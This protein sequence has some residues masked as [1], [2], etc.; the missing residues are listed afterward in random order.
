[1]K[2]KD[3][4]KDGWPEENDETDF[5]T[6]EEDSPELN[7][8]LGW[9][10]CLAAIEPIKEMEVGVDENQFIKIVSNLP[11]DGKNVFTVNLFKEPSYLGCQVLKLN[12]DGIKYLLHA[13]AANL[14]KFLVIRKPYEHQ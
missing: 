14:D 4:I 10:A 2:L 12:E 8:M 5:P 1:M 7:K 9:N 3:L 6:L 13:L 11:H